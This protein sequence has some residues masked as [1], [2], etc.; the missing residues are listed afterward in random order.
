[1]PTRRDDIRNG[2]PLPGRSPQK[3]GRT[4]RFVISLLGL[5]A[6]GLNVSDDVRGDALGAAVARIE[7][8]SQGRDNELRTRIV[9]LER[10]AEWLETRVGQLFLLAFGGLSFGIIEEWLG[11]SWVTLIIAFVIA[12]ALTILVM[13]A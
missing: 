11:R 6:R 7:R 2:S 5:S 1:M 10:Q 4:V 13:E 8:E 3:A 12:I 9:E